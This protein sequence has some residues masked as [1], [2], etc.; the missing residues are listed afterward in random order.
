M[1]RL[2]TLLLF[3]ALGQAGPAEVGAL[4]IRAGETSGMMPGCYLAGVDVSGG[5][6]AVRAINA[7]FREVEHARVLA[8]TELVHLR[9]VIVASEF[10]SLPAKLGC[11]PTEA[12]ERRIWVELSQRRHGVTLFERGDDPL[13]LSSGRETQRGF[14]VW[15]AI[16]E[17]AAFAV[18]PECQSG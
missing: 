16:E 9:R 14:M 17:L 10:F 2:V 12:T 8:E 5:R 18:D 13:C 15:D 4:R 3:A 7:N 11:L 6:I 1:T